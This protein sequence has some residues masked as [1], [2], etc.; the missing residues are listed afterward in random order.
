[1]T[2]EKKKVG[3]P[4]KVYPENIK[5][6]ILQLLGEGKS[7]VV[8]CKREDM[9][10]RKMV[11]KWIQ[12]NEKFRNRYARAKELCAEF[13]ADLILELSQ[14]M[15]GRAMKGD[16]PNA[17]VYAVRAHLDVIKWTAARLS[18]KKYGVNNTISLET[19]E[20]KPAF[21]IHFDESKNKDEKE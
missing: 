5:E 4:L 12:T 11:H 21:S 20:G 9:P 1:M 6:E 7:L 18:P 19:T 2:D 17:G 15:V 14:S 13:H 3:R 16:L 8:I 10:T